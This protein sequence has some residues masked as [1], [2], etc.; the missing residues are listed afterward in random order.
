MRAD[1][2]AVRAG[3][4]FSNILTV[5]AG[6]EQHRY[7]AITLGLFYISKVGR[8]AGNTAGDNHTISPHELDR[9]SGYAQ[10]HISRDRV[11]RMLLLNVG[12][13]LHALG[14][15]ELAVA[16]QLGS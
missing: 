1:D 14:A 8:T 7:M 4:K 5:Y 6:A 15:D 13:N 11:R 10:A 12:P 9:F 3:I 16:E 2:K